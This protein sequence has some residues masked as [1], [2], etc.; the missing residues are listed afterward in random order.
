MS[1]LSLGL[2]GLGVVGAKTAELL[3]SQADIWQ[4][5]TGK[6]LTLTAVSARDR[7]KDRGIDLTGVDFEEDPVALAH[8]GDIDVVIDRI[9]VDSSLKQRLE[10]S[11]QTTLFHG[12]GTMVVMKGSSHQFRVSQR[13]RPLSGVIRSNTARRS[14]LERRSRL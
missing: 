5:K 1:H 2:A 7:T 11:V 4:Q 13:A 9:K 14:A 8:R 12:K 3:M 6:K 10:H